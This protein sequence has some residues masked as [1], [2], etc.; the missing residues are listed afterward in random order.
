MTSYNKYATAGLGL[1][2]LGVASG[3]LMISRRIVRRE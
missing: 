3:L 2:G 1:I